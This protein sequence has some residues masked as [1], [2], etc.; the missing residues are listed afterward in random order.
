MR[1]LTVDSPSTPEVFG[2]FGSPIP[3]GSAATSSGGASSSGGGRVAG[4]KKADRLGAAAA[5]AAKGV[6]SVMGGGGKR[7]AKGFGGPDRS[8]FQDLERRGMGAVVR[9]PLANV[10]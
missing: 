8:P 9:S 4:G 3:C 6:E 10:R 2:G 1:T 5:A 7:L